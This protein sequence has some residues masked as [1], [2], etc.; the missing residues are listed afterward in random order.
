M[1]IPVILAGGSGSRLW[2]L[3]RSQHPK[4]LL[5]L[6]ST[7]T[8]LQETVLR[9]AEVLECAK[10]PFVICQQDYKFLVKKQLSDIGVTNPLIA[11]E[12][13]GKNTAPA[14]AIAALKLL[15]QGEDPLLLVLP[16]DHFI[17]E[18]LSFQAAISEAIPYANDGKLVTFGVQP[19]HPETGYGYIKGNKQA[20]FKIEAFVEKPDME[21]ASAYLAAGDYFWNSGMFFFKASAFLQELQKFTPDILEACKKTL[22]HSKEE[23]G[24]LTLNREYFLQSPADSIDYA[25]MEK[26]Q[27]AIVI[28]LAA[29]WSDV[30]SWAQLWSTHTADENGNVFRGDVI[31]QNVKKSY[32]H[33]ESRMLAVVGVEDHVI[34]ETPDAVLVARRE[35]SQAVKELVQQLKEKKRVEADV[36]KKVHRP[37][38]FY[39][40]LN[41]GPNYQVKRLTVMPG[42]SLSFQKHFH[43][44]E[45][46]V[47]VS[48]TAKVRLEDN[49]LMLS[50]D[51]SIYIPCEARHQLSNPGNEVLQVIEVQSGHY[52]G[53]DDI[54]RFS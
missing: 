52:L 35:D 24:F 22:A 14:I 26:T 12:P 13:V 34:V 36:H 21:T 4:Q 42:E 38:G 19:T 6:L 2:P 51:Q 23:D 31:A 15:Q 32:M 3:S 28:P 17:K 27:N 16:A 44:S 47:V 43:R 30:G 1:I 33:A 40:I 10:T 46:W 37:W 39:E 11:L 41:I 25:V 54:I 18:G 9:T 49:E 50:V 48:G 5:P 7:Y 29:G 45:H 53:E 8:L 20:G